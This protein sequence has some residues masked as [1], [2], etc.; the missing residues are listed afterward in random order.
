[1]GFEFQCYQI[2]TPS[3]DTNVKAIFCRLEGGFDRIAE[4]FA[5]VSVGVRRG[6]VLAHQITAYL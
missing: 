3:L 6:N 5:V 4:S 2:V 1:L